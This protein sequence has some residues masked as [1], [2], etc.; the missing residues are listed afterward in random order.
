MT[1]ERFAG[2]FMLA[3]SFIV[4]IPVILQMRAREA[5]EARFRAAIDR[6]PVT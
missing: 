4:A 1:A 2:Y 6:Q 5:K 3:T